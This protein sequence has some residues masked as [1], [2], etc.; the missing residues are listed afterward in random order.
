[1]GFAFSGEAGRRVPGR[2]ELPLHFKQPRFAGGRI[3]DQPDQA[4]RGRKGFGR[5]F[6]ALQPG[7]KRV[8]HRVDGLADGSV[9]R[10]FHE[11]GVTIVHARTSGL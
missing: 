10:H 3:H 9:D 4:Q 5:N 2:V 11:V 7:V 1:M 8:A 6:Q